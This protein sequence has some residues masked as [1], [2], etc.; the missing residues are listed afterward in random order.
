M[1]YKV[2]SY[3]FEQRLCKVALAWC[4]ATGSPTASKSYM[5]A[6][7]HLYQLTPLS[8]NTN[9]DR[10][11]VLLEGANSELPELNSVLLWYSVCL[12]A[13]SAEHIRGSF[14]TE[15]RWSLNG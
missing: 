3:V 1:S 11:S 7:N 15:R 10:L 2:Y 13:F 5:Y 12:F 14:S 9:G 8:W 6:H 4:G